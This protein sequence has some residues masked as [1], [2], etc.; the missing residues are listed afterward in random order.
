MR[1]ER[2]RVIILEVYEPWIYCIHHLCIQ[3]LRG[4]QLRCYSEKV[5]QMPY[6]KYIMPE[7]EY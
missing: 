4:G 2:L 5:A 7:S 1:P 6:E 3:A